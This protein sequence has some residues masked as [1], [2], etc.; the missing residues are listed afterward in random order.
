MAR[1]T[2][3]QQTVA[4]L[5]PL[6]PPERFWV[7]TNG[8][9]ARYR[10]ATD[11]VVQRADHRRAGAAQYRARHRTRSFILSA[12]TRA[13]SSA[14]FP[15]TMSSP[16]KSNF[17]RPGTRGRR[18]AAEARTSSCMGIKPTRRRDRLRI[19]RGRRKTSRLAARAALHRKARMPSRRKSSLLAGNLFL[20]QRHLPLERAHPADALREHLSETAPFW[21]R[22]PPLWHTKVRETFAELYPKCENISIDYAVLEPRSAKGEHSSNLFC[23]RADFGWNDLGSWAALYEHHAAHAAKTTPRTFSKARDSYTLNAG[24]NYVY[25]PE[26]F[27]ATVGVNNLVVVETETALLITTREHSQDVGKIVKYLNE[28]KCDRSWCEDIARSVLEQEAREPSTRRRSNDMQ[29]KFGTDGWRGIIADD[30]TFENVRR[31]AGAIAA[32]VLKNEDPSA[33]LVIGYDTRFGSRRFAQATCR[34]CLPQ[35]GIPVR[36]AND[37]TPTPALSYAVKNLRRRRRSDDHLQPQSMELER[38]E[39]Q[40]ELRRLGHA[41]DHH[42][43]SKRTSAPEPCPRRHGADRRSRFQDAVHRSHLLSSPTWTRSRAPISSSPSTAC[44]ARGAAC[45]RDLR[46]ARHPAR[47]DPQRGQSAVSGDQS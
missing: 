10:A 3:I 14:C 39:V 24:G 43:R 25:A 34:R 13:P 44:T 37:Y 16:T 42:G 1:Q 28:K 38:S 33:G 31:V 5:A 23:L 7:I 6:A 21:R 29:I 32:Y 45:W 41:G 8:T 11:R 40:G 17:A 22:L 46:A 18:I 15:P 2:M 20:E 36:L 27:V 9:S 26:K 35:P 30:F 12:P 4:R 19:H 47:A